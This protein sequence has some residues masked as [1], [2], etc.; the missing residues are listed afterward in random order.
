MRRYVGKARVG[1]TA[2]PKDSA[3]TNILRLEEPAPQPVFVDA[4]GRRHRTLRR[5]VFGVGLAVLLAVLLLWLTQFGASVRPPPAP[6][7]ASVSAGQGAAPD[8]GVVC[9]DR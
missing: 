3:A 7:C 4:S 9:E 8:A 2:A 6:P 1:K 5:L